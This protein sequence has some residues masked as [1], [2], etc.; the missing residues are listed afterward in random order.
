[1]KLQA[2]HRRQGFTLVEIMIVVLIIGILMS[3]AVP[4]FLQARTSGRRSACIGNMKQVETAKN[5]WA[6]DNKKSNGDA[7]AF[8]DLVG[9]TL[10]LK[11]T[12]SCPSAGTYTVNVIGTDIVCDF[13]GHVLP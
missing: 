1:M 3:I 5:Q 6:M 10:Y 7:V 9:S 12:P 13:T 2:F 4:G 11:S 8:T